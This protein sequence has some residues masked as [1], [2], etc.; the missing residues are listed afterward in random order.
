MKTAK[1]IEKVILQKNSQLFYS[2]ILGPKN[3]NLSF[4][5]VVLLRKKIPFKKVFI[6]RNECRNFMK[7]WTSF[8]CQNMIRNLFLKWKHY[9]FIR[10]S[11]KNIKKHLK[12]RI[13]TNFATN[14]RNHRHKWCSC[15][16]RK[17]G[18]YSLR[19]LFWT[20]YNHLAQCASVLGI[21]CNTFERFLTNIFL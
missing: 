2:Y 14:R 4:I 11:L 21:K 6:L 12:K 7:K 17:Q 10:I 9:L 19:S 20:S 8:Y 13:A 16:F 5:D 15:V 18:E 3:L 1:K